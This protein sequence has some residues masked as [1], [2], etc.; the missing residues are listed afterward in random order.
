MRCAGSAGGPR[1]P[2]ATDPNAFATFVIGERTAT[3]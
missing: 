1:C 3:G 2:M